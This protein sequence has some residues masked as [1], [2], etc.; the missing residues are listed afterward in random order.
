MKPRAL[1]LVISHKQA[2]RLVRLYVFFWYKIGHKSGYMLYDEVMQLWLFNDVLLSFLFLTCA[3]VSSVQAVLPHPFIF[4]SHHNNK[5]VYD[6]NSC[7]SALT[8]PF[9][10]DQI[11]QW[12]KV[13]TWYRPPASQASAISYK[14]ES[15]NSAYLAYCFQTTAN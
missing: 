15:R 10:S 4:Q 8:F 7:T 2:I 1:I 14:W 12:G 6:S 3:F 9:H 13:P 5:C 11:P